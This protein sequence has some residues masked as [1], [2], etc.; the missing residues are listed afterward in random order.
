[1][2]CNA[3]SVL[4]KICD[5]QATSCDIKPDVILITESWCNSNIS[6]NVLN[7]NDYELV[8]E[9]RRDREDTTNGIGGG[10]LVYA[11]KGLVI[12]SIDIKI[13]FNQFV[14][15]K[16][17]TKNSDLNVFLIYRPPSCNALN[18][19]KL[20]DIIKSAPKN[21]ILIGDFN[22]PKI[23]WNTLTCDN[24]S[25]DFM[26]AC[27][28]NNFMQYVDFP[29][30]KKDN[31]LDLV[32]A[33]NDCVLNVD[34]LGPLSS[35]DHVMLL[36][37][38]CVDFNVN[39]CNSKQYNWRKADY[40]Q[41]KIEL[42]NVDWSNLLAADNIEENWETFKN[43][44]DNTVK[45]N[46]PL[47]ENKSKKS[48]PIWYND[49]IK[50]LKRKKVRFFRKWKQTKT[51]EDG[52][53]YTI[54]ED[55]L[56]RAIRR[57]KKRIEI[58]I[59]K[60]SGNTGKNTFNKYV[61]S[62]LSKQTSIGPLIGDDR[63][64][65]GDSR[66]MADI[67]NN[68]FSD[69]FIKQDRYS[70]NVKNMNFDVPV[71]N[72]VITKQMIAKKIDDLKFG[73]APG[74]D[75]IST[76][77][78]KNLK[79]E[80]LTPLQILFKQSLSLGKVP[81]DWKNAKVVPIFKKGAKGEPSN[82]RPVSL[83]CA[84]C[85]L[86]ESLIRDAITNHLKINNLIK[87]SQ[88]GFAD[89]RSCQTNLIEFMDF[90]TKR[91]DEGEAVDV[92]YLDFSKAFDKISHKKLIQKLKA[93]GVKGVILDWIEDWL[94]DRKQRVSVN[95][96]MSDEKDVSSSVPQGSV[97]GPILFVIYINDIDDEATAIDLIR[98]FADDTKVAKVI[99]NK[100]DADKLQ[101]C[102]DKLYNWSKKWS[103]EFNVKKC[104]I[105][106]FGKKNLKFKY[107]MNGEELAVVECERDVGVKITSNLKPSDHCTE[108]VGRARW[109]LGQITRCF[110]YR[111]KN[112]FLRLYK[113]Y[114]RPHLEF[115]SVAWSPWLATD[116]TTIENVQIRAI[117]MISSMNGKTYPEKLS[118]LNLWSLEKRRVMFDIVQMYKVA[119]KIG[120][121]KCSFQ[122]TGSSRSGVVT[123]HQT[124]PLNIVK[125]RSNLELRRNFFTVRVADTWNKIPS[126]LKNILPEQKFKKS[127]KLWMNNRTDL[128]R[129]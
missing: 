128:T 34:N 77:L 70:D 66:K 45:K 85:K 109:I 97:L 101:H 100:D 82:Y 12:L 18:N 28:D 47:S 7:V 81:A 42:I 61:K 119:H 1:M 125:E 118:E 56:K 106:H 3:Q 2:Y 32:L 92:V 33:N 122:Y 90:V 8:S 75:G 107:K 108:A 39:E 6:D 88:H 16:I 35:S 26:N 78:L 89:N 51:R 50:R 19:S 86:M 65:T 76:T 72:I 93:H 115:A 104:K 95:G 23:D 64:I 103:M 21:S 4:S 114:V 116:I 62:R 105:I 46:V 10:L 120:D 71:N 13:E 123:R 14:S 126:D 111:D 27:I 43:I 87:N 83:T 84:I 112:V 37:N 54:A 11:R 15:F 99:R 22:F 110:H 94:K 74:P 9:L 113:Q 73:K 60:Q 80:I 67:L 29:T 121:I 24:Y 25:K 30:H 96:F 44:I 124:D 63:E 38:T 127:L 91:V 20:C 48:K 55:E 31:I 98:K 69:V 57:A 129:N 5:L 17:V 68:C 40:D 79:T 102:L 52:V 49:N 53:K 36:V 59:S 41:M 117:N 58:K